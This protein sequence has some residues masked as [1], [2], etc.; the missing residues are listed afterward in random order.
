[1]PMCCT[2]PDPQASPLQPPYPL[3]HPRA[4]RSDI[5]HR[6]RP[7]RSVAGH[8]HGGHR[9]A[10]R[11][12]SRGAACGSHHHPRHRLDADGPAERHHPSPARRGNPWQYHRDLLR[13]DRD[14]HAKP[15]DRARDPRRWRLYH[16]TGSG[17]SFEG[18]IHFEESWILLFP[19]VGMVSNSTAMRA[20]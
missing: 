1:M 10:R 12:R 13:Q 16:V 4:R 3:C 20:R 17:Y 7:G 15:D 19:A 11:S 5:C 18:A 9:A 6:N 14:A 8:V 2:P